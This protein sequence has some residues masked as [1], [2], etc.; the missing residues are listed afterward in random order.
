[1]SGAPGTAGRNCRWCGGVWFGDVAYCPY[2]GHASAS[3]PVATAV[4]APPAQASPPSE[5]QPAVPADPSPSWTS[6]A[7]PL[8]AGALL[9]VLLVII[10]V[11]VLR[12]FGQSP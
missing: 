9:G 3:E 10:A 6:W 7:R 12:N 4:E 11:L 1:M 2:C 5:S 8:A